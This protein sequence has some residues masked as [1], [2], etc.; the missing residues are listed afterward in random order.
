M[1][2]VPPVLVW[3]RQPS[4]PVSDSSVLNILRAPPS[5]RFQNLIQPSRC[6]APATASR[7]RGSP[8]ASHIKSSS[9][10]SLPQ[11]HAISQPE[12]P[13]KP[14]ENPIAH[15]LQSTLVHSSPF[16]LGQSTSHRTAV[17]PW[18]PRPS[19]P[20]PHSSRPTTVPAGADPPSPPR[21]TPAAADGARCGW[22]A[23]R[24]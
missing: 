17:G 11:P 2:P 7:S 8:L 19:P 1:D 14:N 13:P 24:W 6:D 3:N 18:R 23:R 10:L 5:R 12:Q 15:T 4:Q 16:L 22:R 9:P 21:S 20:R